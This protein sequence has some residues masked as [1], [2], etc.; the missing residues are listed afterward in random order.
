MLF[1][2]LR[3]KAYDE[4]LELLRP[5]ADQW[6]FAT[7]ATP[8]GL[9]ASELAAR[10]GG[11][12]FDDVSRALRSA[13]KLAGRRGLVVAAGSIFLM[14]AVRAELLGKRSDPPIAM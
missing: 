9:P 1:G 4:M 8:R 2:V 13:R 12:A 6:V 3:D 5:H 10:W 14:S 11:L 7:P